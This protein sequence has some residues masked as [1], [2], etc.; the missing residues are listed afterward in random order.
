MSERKHLSPLET[1]F[2]CSLL[3]APSTPT[4]SPEVETALRRHPGGTA[5][6]LP[7]W[8]SQHRPRRISRE[9]LFIGKINISHWFHFFITFVR[10]ERGV[11][12]EKV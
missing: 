2:S 3:A 11:V 6:S 10:R 9:K 8:W 7:T 12:C 5:S 4:S 1:V